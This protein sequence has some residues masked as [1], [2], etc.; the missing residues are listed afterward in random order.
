MDSRTT[1]ATLPLAQTHSQMTV[2]K[3]LDSIGRNSQQSRRI[4]G[5]GLSHFQGFLY[6]EYGIDC[7]IDSIVDDI[8]RNKI[9]V[10]SLLDSFVSYLR[11]N[12]ETSK[13]SANSIFLYVAAVR[14]YL[15]YYDFDIVPA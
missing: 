11:G 10:Y 4:Y 5:F 2:A 8:L 1:F 13:L 15:A 12:G 3:F 7:T 6:N 9:N 14:S